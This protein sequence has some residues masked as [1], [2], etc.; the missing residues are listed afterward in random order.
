MK[1]QFKNV[2]TKNDPSVKKYPN[3]VIKYAVRCLLNKIGIPDTGLTINIR[4]KIG[5]IAREYS[6]AM[7]HSSPKYQP[8][9]WGAN[10]IK[11][12]EK[13]IPKIND[14]FIVRQKYGRAFLSSLIAELTSA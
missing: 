12:I 7:A 11:T 3:D 9:I 4:N 14:V 2:A 10:R 5:R 13:G 1:V 8:N 6:P